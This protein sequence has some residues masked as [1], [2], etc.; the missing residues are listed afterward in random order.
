MGGHIGNQQKPHFQDFP[1]EGG[2]TRHFAV[3]YSTYWG[4]IFCLHF[5][6]WI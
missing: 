5:S 3:A 4:V 6:K 2:V 1:T